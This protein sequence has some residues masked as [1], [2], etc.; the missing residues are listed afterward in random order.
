VCV[1][2]CH[3]S[4]VGMPHFAVFLMQQLEAYD[5]CPLCC[6]YG[7]VIYPI[8]YRSDVNK[9]CSRIMFYCNLVGP[10]M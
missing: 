10:E 4:W 3:V 5:I 8:P 6:N 1:Y 2:I 7:P 9:G